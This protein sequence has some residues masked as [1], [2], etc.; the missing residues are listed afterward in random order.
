MWRR[1]NRQAGGRWLRKLIPALA[2][3]AFVA[4]AACGSVDDDPHDRPYALRIESIGVDTAVVAI[5]SSRDGV[6]E[7]PD[8]ADL[9]GWWSQ[10]AALGEQTGSAV[11]VGH[12]ASDGGGVFD[13]V[14]DLE[15]GDLIEIDGAT[16]TLA[17]RVGSV[18]VVSKDEFPGEAQRIF[19]QDANGRLVLITCVDWDGSTWRSN[20]VAI[21]APVQA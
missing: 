4:V 17:Y 18:E 14:G 13:A 21:A 6:L 3:S 16:Q 19:D 7:P 9:A 15:V 2:G 8:D 1:R 12:S 10:G 20:V 11:V 5:D